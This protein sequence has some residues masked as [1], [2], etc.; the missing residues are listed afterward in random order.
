LGTGDRTFQFERRVFRPEWSSFEAFV[1]PGHS[2]GFGNEMLARPMHSRNYRYRG[3]TMRINIPADGFDLTSRM[4]SLVETRLLPALGQFRRQIEF[5]RVDLRTHVGRQEPD[6][7]ISEITASLRPAGEV[8]VQT[9][10]PQM[11]VSI[12][13]AA[14]AIRAQSS[15]RLRS[16]RRSLDRFL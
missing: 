8:R 5:V 14:Q 10:D 2:P 4:R 15:A 16:D 13:R 12:E 11:Q 6:T 7:A 1:I 9:G 3:K